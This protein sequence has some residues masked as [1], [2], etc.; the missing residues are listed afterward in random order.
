MVRLGPLVISCFS[1]LSGCGA[2]S[3]EPVAPTSQHSGLGDNGA[4][5]HRER[6]VGSNIER[7]VCRSPEQASRDRE[8]A[9]DLMRPGR[10]PLAEKSRIP[11]V[12]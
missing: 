8:E 1:A 5:C 10:V 6:R 12:N 7:E 9:R 3:R 2:P 11:G 4:G